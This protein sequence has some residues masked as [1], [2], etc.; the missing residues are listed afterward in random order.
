MPY[1]AVVDDEEAVRKA[2]GRLLRASGMQV[3][4]FAGGREFLDAALGRRP[5]CAV[6]DLHMPGMSGLQVL[7]EL[8]PALPVIVITAHDSTD[9]RDQCLAAG[10]RIYLRKP[11]EASV[12]L[13]AIST[14][15]R[16][17]RTENQ[18]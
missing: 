16:P 15:L 6:L 5:D 17:I 9:V 1:I 7:H 8:R 3:D 2:L 10:A 12:L 4:C 14:C 18:S 11:L 13:E